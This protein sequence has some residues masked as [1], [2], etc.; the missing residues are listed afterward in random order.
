MTVAGG[1]PERD[2][3]EALARELGMAAHVAFPGRLEPDRVAAL[4]GEAD[5][6]VNASLLD[7]M[8]NSLLEA[9][10]SGVPIVSTDVCGIPFLVEHGKTALLVPPRDPAAMARAVLDLL[11]DPPLAEQMVRAGRDLAQQFTWSH[12]RP[13]LLDVYA[14]LTGGPAPKATAAGR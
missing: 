10:A 7:N 3:L 9:L 14:A 1:G 12:V 5:V 8:P 6:V 2:A 13:R 11:D 4:Y